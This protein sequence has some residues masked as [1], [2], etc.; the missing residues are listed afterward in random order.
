MLTME[1]NKVYL[2]FA[3]HGR[4]GMDTDIEHMSMLEAFLS[5]QRLRQ[6]LPLCEAIYYSPISRAAM[7]AKFYGLG[8]HCRHLLAKR[9]LEEDM[10]TF[11]IRRFIDNIIQ[12]ST[13]EEKHYHFVTHQPVIEKLGLPNLETC[14]LCWC[15]ADSW[16]DMLSENYEIVK[17]P[18]V[19]HEELN[20]LLEKLRID[21]A[22]LEKFSPDA[23]YSALSRVK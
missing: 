21:P 10:S 14:G 9:E 11:V 4:Y 20:R 22:D 1:N 13:P 5:G 3:R 6:E 8:M 7:T 12:N 19:S 15:V 2:S 17:G 18:A 23:I 16:Q